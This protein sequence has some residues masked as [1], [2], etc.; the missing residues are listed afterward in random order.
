MFRHILTA[1]DGSSHSKRAVETAARLA[2]QLDAN[3]LSICHVVGTGPIPTELAHMAEV[4]HLAS[5]KRA[6]RPQ[7][8]ANILGNLA[9]VQ[10]DDVAAE[11]RYEVRLAISR[12]ILD[13]ASKIAVNLDAPG[14]ETVL[15]EGEPVPQILELADKLGADLIV[16]GS[17]GLSELKGILMGSVSHKICQFS[18]YPCLTVR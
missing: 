12:R 5:G 6:A 17:R 7:N 14:V 16:V 3:L 15:L 9:T 18:R 1:V 10:S 8:V 4:E 13:D 2:K 11:L